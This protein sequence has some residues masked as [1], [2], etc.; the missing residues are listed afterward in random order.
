[1]KMKKIPKIDLSNYNDEERIPEAIEQVLL[2]GLI[3]FDCDA[4]KVAKYFNICEEKVNIVYIKWYSQLLRAITMKEKSEELDNAINTGIELM[5]DHLAE[6][7]KTRDASN[8]K[9]MSQTLTRNVNSIVDRLVTIKENS[10]KT[11]DTVTNK[12]IDNIVKVKTI[13]KLEQ[14]EIVNNSDYNDNT[15]SVSDR[16]NEYLSKYR[17]N[18]K[19]CKVEDMVTGDSKVFNTMSD[20]ARALG[21]TPSHVSQVVKSGKLYRERYMIYYVEEDRL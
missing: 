9:L 15:K 21:T 16:L 4:K 13:E 11:Y 2:N 14:G 5:S 18:S 8:S 7:K 12:L 10:S 20:A 19:I 6:V 1:M 17:N 3:F